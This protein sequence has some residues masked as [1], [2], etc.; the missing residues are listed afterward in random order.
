M[1]AFSVVVSHDAL[2]G[3]FARRGVY[4]FAVKWIQVRLP[5]FNSKVVAWV[6]PRSSEMTVLVGRPLVFGALGVFY[7]P[8]LDTAE[9]GG[10]RGG[11]A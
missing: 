3:I 11:A 7:L 2:G 6:V 5:S 9:V 4:V 8:W 10:F 1:D